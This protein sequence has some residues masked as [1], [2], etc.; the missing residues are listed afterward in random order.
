MVRTH[1]G[2]PFYAKEIKTVKWP[3]KV[4]HSAHILERRLF[5][6]RFGK[7]WD[8]L[9]GFLVR[10]IQPLTIATIRSGNPYYYIDNDGL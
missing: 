6:L 4:G 7:L 1:H 10:K 8:R 3:Q 9:H 2:S 5:H